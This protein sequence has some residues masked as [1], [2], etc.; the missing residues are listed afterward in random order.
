MCLASGAPNDDSGNDNDDS[1]NE[2][3]DGG[4]DDDGCFQAFP[5]QRVV[6]VT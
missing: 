2:Y 3:Y 5:R 1:N 6:F 4:Y